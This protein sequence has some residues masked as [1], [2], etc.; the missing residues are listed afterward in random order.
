MAQGFF[1][2]FAAASVITALAVVLAR[3]PVHSALA[4]MA[5]FLQ[6]SAIFVLLEAPLLAVI[7][8]F[9]YVGA[10]MVL[11]LFVIMMI[12]VREAVLQRFLPG[13]NLPAM[14]LL[15]VLGVEMLVL[16]LWSNRFSITEPVGMGTAGDIR[17][18]ST[19]LFAEYLLPFEAASVILLAALVGAI[20]LARKEPG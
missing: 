18:L 4:L 3:N 16:V 7:Q 8:I 14:A 13:G 9:V 12:D 6:I 17:L 2:L 20:V 11:F 10:I 15:V 19:T 5:C 1:L